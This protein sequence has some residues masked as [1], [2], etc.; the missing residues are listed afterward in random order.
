MKLLGEFEIE[1]HGWGG[2]KEFGECLF[3]HF[4]VCL[5]NFCCFYAEGE[6]RLVGED[7]PLE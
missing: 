5:S 3:V 4:L 7:S 2:I 1:S 6:M